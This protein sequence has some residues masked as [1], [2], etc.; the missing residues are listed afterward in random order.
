MGVAKRSPLQR[1]ENTNA[2]VSLGQGVV[3]ER[4]EQ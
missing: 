4:E 2:V 3:K 1:R